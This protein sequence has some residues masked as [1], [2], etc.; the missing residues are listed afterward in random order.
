MSQRS[1]RRNRKKNLGKMKAKRPLRNNRTLKKLPNQLSM[2][3]QNRLK[4]R[5]SR[6]VKMVRRSL[7]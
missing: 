1:K 3:S 7:K 6:K 2:K 5:K 4:R